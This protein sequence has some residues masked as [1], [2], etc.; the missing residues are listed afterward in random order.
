MQV[1]VSCT[2]ICLH[3]IIEFWKRYFAAMPVGATTSP[4]PYNSFRSQFIGS[5]LSVMW[6]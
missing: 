4:N 5:K 2:Y 3:H 1:N 6:W